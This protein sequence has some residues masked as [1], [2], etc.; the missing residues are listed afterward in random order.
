M[1]LL[2]K[3]GNKI[4]NMESTDKKARRIAKAIVTLLMSAFIAYIF[5]KEPLPPAIANLVIIVVVF[6]KSYSSIKREIFND[7]K[8][9]DEE[10]DGE[11]E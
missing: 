11:V 3:N 10:E 1:V 2:Q 9:K 7:F 5:Y 8:E 6:F 4:I